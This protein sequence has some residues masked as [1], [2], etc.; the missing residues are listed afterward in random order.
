MSETV[1]ISFRI[2]DGVITEVD[3]HRPT[4]A[5]VTGLTDPRDIEDAVA[6]VAN[7]PVASK[8]SEEK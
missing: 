1:V 6:R 2:V 5:R 4:V 7:T 3:E 8:I